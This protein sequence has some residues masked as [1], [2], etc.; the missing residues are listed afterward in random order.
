MASLPANGW[1]NPDDLLAENYLHPKGNHPSELRFD[2]V[3]RF[4]E[5]LEEGEKYY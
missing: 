5:D 4:A 2:R 3:S 1:P